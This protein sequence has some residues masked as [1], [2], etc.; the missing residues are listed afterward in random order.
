MNLPVEAE[1]IAEF[2]GVETR[3]PSKDQLAGYLASLNTR[4]TGCVS[5]LID[6]GPVRG[7]RGLLGPKRD[8]VSCFSVEWDGAYASL[9]FHDNAWSEYRAIDHERPVWPTDDERRKIAHGELTPPP[10]DECM[11]KTRAFTAIS[12]FLRIGA[13]PGWLSYKYVR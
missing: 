2:D 11:D 10:Q 7:W 8:V 1:W 5:V 9:I 3:F 4:P 13:R 6:R 12:E